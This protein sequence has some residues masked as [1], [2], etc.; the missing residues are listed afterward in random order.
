[1]EPSGLSTCDARRAPL[2]GVTVE[3]GRGRDRFE[4]VA[5][6]VNFLSRRNFEGVEVELG[7]QDLPGHDQR[8]LDF[9]NGLGVVVALQ[10]SDDDVESGPR[11]RD[12]DTPADAAA[13]SGDECGSPFASHARLAEARL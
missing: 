5:G 1:M 2:E 3:Y 11:Q 10:I 4:A 6:V 7:Y 8:D 12:G 9:A 13:T